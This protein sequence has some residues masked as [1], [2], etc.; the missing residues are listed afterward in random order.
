MDSISYSREH[1]EGSAHTML[2]LWQICSLSLGQPG[3]GIVAGKAARVKTE[4]D[5]TTT[6]SKATGNVP[7]QRVTLV[8]RKLSWE[9]WKTQRRTCE[10]C[11]R[12]FFPARGNQKVCCGP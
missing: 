1:S 11:R 10:A 3:T 8:R 5:M 4:N 12:D 6:E 9:A 2:T 7:E